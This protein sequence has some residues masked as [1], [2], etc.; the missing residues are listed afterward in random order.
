M[1]RPVFVSAAVV[2][3]LTPTV[4][5]FYAGGYFDGPRLAAATLVW[6]LVCLLV[7]TG[8][9]R[10]PRSPAG[11]LALGGLAA[12]M[13]WSALSLLWAPLSEPVVDTTQRLL[14]YLGATLLAVAVFQ[15]ERFAQLAAPAYAFGATAVIG[16]GLSGRVLPGVVTQERAFKAAGRL[17]QPITYWN[18][19]GL[20]AAV[21]FLLCVSLAGDGSRSRFVRAAAAAA[22]APLGVG[23]YLSYSR[24]ALAAVVI[25]LLVL[26]AAAPRWPMVRAA[27]VGLV[28]AALAAVPAALLEGVAVLEGSPGQRRADGLILGAVLLVVVVAAAVDALVSARRQ[29]SGAARTGTRR[30]PGSCPCW[31]PARP[32]CR[33]SCWWPGAWASRPIRRTPAPGPPLLGSPRWGPRAM[34]TG[35]WAST[36]S[37]QVPCWASAP[38]AFAA[39]GCGRGRC[40][41]RPWRSIRS[42]WRRS[43][44]WGFPGR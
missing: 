40:R 15:H 4:L 8:D 42:R 32:C 25:G 30:G 12:L 38:E 28:V 36:P 13:A 41:R 2:V 43:P 31:P 35:A 26:L 6:L 9:L 18:A 16:Y 33:S 14:L 23:T 20:L 19:E 37:R 44:S 1:R 10:L 39:S 5:A 17:E 3:L 29:S 21:G 27:V 34:T 11:R 24:G 22:C 7:A